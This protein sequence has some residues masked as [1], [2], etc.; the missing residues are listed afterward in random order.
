M[1]NLKQRRGSPGQGMVEF[2]MVFPLL[3]I[4]LFGIFE[5][6]RIMFA[7]S[8]VVAAS[9]EAARYGAAI[10]DTGGGISQ[11]EDCAGIREAAKRV[12]RYAGVTDADISIQYS[13]SSGVY[14]T[15]C[16]PTQDVSPADTIS[17]TIDTSITPISIIGN[18]SPI[19][20]NSSTS[21]TI[22]KSVEL[23][24]SGTGA[25]SMSGALTD[26]NFKTTYQTVEET[27]GTIAVVVELNSPSTDT[28]S[29]PFSVTGT[30]VQG[31]GA[32]Y[33][34]SASPVTI[35]PGDTTATIYVV[36]NNDG[37]AEGDESLVIGLDT[38][39]N[40]TRG[41]QYIHTIKIVDPPFI[42]FKEV[43]SVHAENSPMTALMV[44]LSKGSSQDVSVSF[45]R[46]GTAK[47]GVGNDY[48]TSPATL[49]I[50]SGSLSA[51][52][53]LQI[54]DDLIDEEDEVGVITL[55]S[56]VNGLIGSNSSHALTI[57][58]DDDP[59]QVSFY[60]ANQVVS[61]EIGKFVTTITLSDISGKTIVVP[62]TISGTTIPADYVIHDPSPLTILPGASSVDIE[63]DILEGDG[64][65][66][67]ETLILTLGDPT[68]ASLGSP[69]EQTIVITESSTQPTAAFSK[70]SQTVVEGDVVVNLDVQLSNAW[71]APVRIHFSASGT[72]LQG[73]SDDYMVSVS[74]LEIPVGWTQGTIQ[75][76]VH[77]DDIDEDTENILV[78]MGTI[79]NGLP[80]SQTTSQ[81]Q[82]LDDD[83]PPKIYFSVGSKTALETAGTVTVALEMDKSSVHDVSVPLLL[84]G[85]ASLNTDYSISA[86]KV[87]I[88]AGSTSGSFQ[89]TIIDDA[90]YDPGEKAVVSIG[91]PINAEVGS[92]AAFT[93]LIEDNEISHCKV[94]AHLLTI[95]TDSFGLSMVNEGEDLV[96]TGGSVTWT[97]AA[98]NQP[99]LL[100]VDFAGAE[101]FS[102]SVKP[103][104]FGYTG[105]EAFS[106]LDTQSV[107]F[108]F[109][110]QLGTGT[111]VIY[112]TFQNT[113]DG[114]TCSLTET[115]TVH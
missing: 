84:S 18:F 40:A 92:P 107:S 93:L 91:T 11:Y 60:V 67:D 88:P 77:E 87:V 13:N 21:R 106:S 109:D 110:G 43:S 46:S 32:D 112:S 56:P 55:D 38:P 105:S 49:T 108:Q 25:G 28:V 20:V 115:F 62:Y 15:S 4:L 101:I 94:G 12:G 29:V 59:P 57:I 54:N 71:S 89:I 37:L 6:S 75:V 24:F 78:S 30:A 99:R 33:Q 111:H 19:P 35:N 79:E 96:Y 41:P 64:M 53:T 2:A 10:L 74:P 76:L 42:S 114:S 80:G 73:V 103:P 66:P 8:A 63:M 61:E 7:Y 27:Q 50:P 52:L 104:S 69:A 39:I 82:I 9:R 34:I 113:A 98:S 3:L 68:N 31:A 83:S 102:G 100:S 36:L 23:G 44:E 95:G 17:V 97:E 16:P 85:S 5:F 47:W 65:E 70:A 26:V 14:S 86:A 72:A 45:T 48:L 1:D 22:L 51:M 90:V 58:D 81:V